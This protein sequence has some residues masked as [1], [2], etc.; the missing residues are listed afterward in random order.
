MMR[1]VGLVLALAT[2]VLAACG[3]A[4]KTDFTPESVAQ[5][6]PGFLFLYTD[7]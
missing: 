2:L 5:E 1:T 6:Q 4:E 7:N 3:G